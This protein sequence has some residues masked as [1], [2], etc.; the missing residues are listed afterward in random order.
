MTAARSG[1]AATF[2]ESSANGG[3]VRGICKPGLIFTELY[4]GGRD[5]GMLNGIDIPKYAGI[6]RLY[7]PQFANTSGFRTRLNLIN[8]N[9][10]QDAQVTVI[11][12]GSDGQVLTPP[13]TL[14]IPINGQLEEDVNNL[15]GQDPSIQNASG[16]LEVD[17]SADR[18][19]GAVTFTNSS[20]TL[21]SSLELSGTPLNHFVFP[22]AA[23]D[24]TYQTGIALLNTNSSTA[25]VTL[26]LWGPG[27]TLDRTTSFKL[28][29]GTRTAQYLG[30]YFPNLSSYLVAN[31]RVRSDQP[32]HS[33]AIMNDRSLHFVAAIPA[34]PFPEVP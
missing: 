16:W 9:A 1:Q 26:E 27:G 32:I 20:S 5:G 3:Y 4:G 25:N 33:I 8:G 11:L 14:I 6:T 13:Y 15:F 30:D 29:P 21:F 31:I 23:E 10:S 24:G 7:A 12:H 34:V 18:I 19:V 22:I 17:S 2:L 28:G